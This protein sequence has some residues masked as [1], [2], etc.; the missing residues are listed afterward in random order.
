MAFREIAVKDFPL[1]PFTSVGQ[2]WALI[3][4]G[5]EAAFNTMTVSWGGFGF[6]WDYDVITVYIRP[7]RYTNK[8]VEQ[9][10]S[11]SLSFFDGYK[12]ELAKL[13]V[14]S[15]RD[16]DKAKEVNFHPIFLE[17]VPTF[18]EAKVVIVAEKIYEDMIKPELLKDKSV[19]ST[20]YPEK[21]YH[22]LYIA[23]VKKIYVND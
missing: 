6:L 9:E 17:G 5:T 18:E 21:D 12:P 23:R 22:I 8:F 10:D 20:W 1:N 19:D 11:F 14:L 3:T 4:A 7:Q 2:D 13:G 15:G 16:V